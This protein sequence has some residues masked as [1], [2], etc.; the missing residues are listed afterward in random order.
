MW[1]LQFGS[2]TF[3]VNSAKLQWY[4]S[5]VTRTR[6]ARIE[7][8][9]NG[10]G[11]ER[12]ENETDQPD[13]RSHAKN[14]QQLRSLMHSSACYNFIFSPLSAGIKIRSGSRKGYWSSWGRRKNPK[15]ASSWKSSSNSIWYLPCV[16]SCRRR[17]RISSSMQLPSYEFNI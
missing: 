10:N 5:P 13:L 4:L 9:S 8:E 12:S 15:E 1:G 17:M 11:A 2:R 14:V 6:N 3:G 16:T 7:D